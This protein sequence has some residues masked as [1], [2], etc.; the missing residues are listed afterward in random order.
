MSRVGGK[1][2]ADL[3]CLIGKVTAQHL[4]SAG[5]SILRM[6]DRIRIVKAKDNGSGPS[7][8]R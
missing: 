8:N 1:T 6:I 3:I 4:D 7:V 2:V 5:S